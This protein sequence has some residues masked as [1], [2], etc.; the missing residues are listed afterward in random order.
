M[1]IVKVSSDEEIIAN[2]EGSF[3][4]EYL[5]KKYSNQSASDLDIMLNSLCFVILKMMVVHVDKQKR[6]TLLRLVNKILKS[7]MEQM[8][9]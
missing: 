6:N 2:A 8:D 9:E 3:L 1:K 5:I 7:G 4:Y